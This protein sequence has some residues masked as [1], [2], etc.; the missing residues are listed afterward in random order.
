MVTEPVGRLTALSNVEG[1]SQAAELFRAG[2]NVI[3]E[4]ASPAYIYRGKNRRP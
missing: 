4:P 2:I 1:S 3:P